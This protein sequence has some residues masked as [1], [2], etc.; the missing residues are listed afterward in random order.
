MRKKHNICYNNKL[1]FKMQV[2]LEFIWWQAMNCSSSKKGGIRVAG[3]AWFQILFSIADL[4]GC[5][6]FYCMVCRSAGED[7]A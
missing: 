1:K 5:S 3:F 7:F 4:S 2:Y 6:H